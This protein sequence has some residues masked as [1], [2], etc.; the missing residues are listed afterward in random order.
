MIDS[1][2][3]FAAKD[4]IQT[5]CAYPPEQEKQIEMHLSSGP[6]SLLFSLS[7][8]LSLLVL[9]ASWKELKEQAR[10]IACPEKCAEELCPK[11]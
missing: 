3:P 8:F 9:W 4:Y 2:G 1:D 7:N 11:C 10:F 5:V 6:V